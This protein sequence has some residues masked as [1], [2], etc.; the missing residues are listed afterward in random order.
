MGIDPTANVFDLP[1][2]EDQT[3]L[4][5]NPYNL[6][7][8]TKTKG[9]DYG[10][11]NGRSFAAGDLEREV[12][13]WDKNFQIVGFFELGAGV[14]ANGSVLMS[15]DGYGRFFPSDTVNNVNFGLVVLKAGVDAEQF[16]AATAGSPFA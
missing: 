8:D 13:I 2:I 12:E 16:A 10:A 7:I 9:K 14:A 1:E 4:L 15:S 6:L 5:T 11:V 3:C